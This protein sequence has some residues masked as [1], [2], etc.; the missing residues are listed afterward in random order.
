MD[1]K[2]LV[3]NVM[4]CAYCKAPS[5]FNGIAWCGRQHCSTLILM[6]GLGHLIHRAE[7]SSADEMT[8]L[9]DVIRR[10][11]VGMKDAKFW[12]SAEQGL[13][14]EAATKALEKAAKECGLEIP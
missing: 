12:C 14:P 9:R 8:K 5:M 10:L 7:I 3:D 13:N 11:L 4:P 1:A 6:Q 2:N